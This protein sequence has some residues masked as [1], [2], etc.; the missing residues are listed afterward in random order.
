MG[1]HFA[2]NGS[3]LHAAKRWGIPVNNG[4]IPSFFV[5]NARFAWFTYC[6]AVHQYFCSLFRQCCDGIG[7]QKPLTRINW[8]CTTFSDFGNSRV[9][10]K[11]AVS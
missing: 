2:Y 5:V 4:G 11:I 6:S 3:S 10:S 8:C 7:I 1:V 9:S